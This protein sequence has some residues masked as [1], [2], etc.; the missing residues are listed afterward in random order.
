MEGL[1]QIQFVGENQTGSG[2]SVIG[3]DGK[4]GIWRGVVLGHLGQRPEIK[5][6]TIQEVRNPAN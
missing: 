5:W 6:T 2:W 4:G 3:L 1:V